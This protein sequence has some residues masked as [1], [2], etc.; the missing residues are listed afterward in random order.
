MRELNELKAE[1]FTRSE[2]RIK[3]RKRNRNRIIALCVPLCLI[4]SVL[5][6]TL[7]RDFLPVSHDG[8]ELGTLGTDNK[9]NG[10]NDEAVLDGYSSS[11]S[12]TCSY[13]EVLVTTSD[14][15]E[16]PVK[17]TD[18][19]KVTQ[20]FSAVF[21]SD[22][23][24]PETS[25]GCGKESFDSLESQDSNFEGRPTEIVITFLTDDGAQTVYKLKENELWN[26]DEDT[27]TLLCDE[28]VEEL[29]ALLGLEN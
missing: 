21:V 5:S 9:Y 25:A 29:K 23:S 24:D 28:Q 27:T 3:E 20:I 15:A 16:E 19:V 7:L 2:K 26:E 11:N 1:V 22:D 12:L 17:I 6:V 4:I 8:T 18:K 14:S 10:I 13:T